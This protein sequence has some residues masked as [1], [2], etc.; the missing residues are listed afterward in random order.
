MKI[1]L[2]RLQGTS[3]SEQEDGRML[4]G[5]MT[6]KTRNILALGAIVIL[7]G[8]LV[9]PG[10]AIAKGLKFLGIQGI[11][12][13]Q[14]D[15]TTAHQLLTGPASL[16]GYFVSNENVSQSPGEIQVAFAPPAGTAGVLTGLRAT[17]F[18]MSFGASI[19]W[20]IQSGGCA[21]NLKTVDEELPTSTN[22]IV[23]PFSPGQIVP[24][25]DQ[26]CVFT[27]NTSAY[28]GV[29]GYTVPA[30]GAPTSP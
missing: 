29:T 7:A 20:S 21:T 4:D 18:S 5:I 27:Y 14:V 13:S 2:S 23:V 22:T 15:V 19:T 26:V 12:G 9:L 25:G 1:L 24:A 8:M 3:V 30:A 28:L 16:S 6:I 11:S 10:G 17:P